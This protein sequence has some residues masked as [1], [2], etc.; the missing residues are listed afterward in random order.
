MQHP[1]KIVANFGTLLKLASDLGKANQ[2]GD[3]SKIA[4]AQAAHDNYCEIIKIAD[5]TLVGTILHE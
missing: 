3:K 1:V 4:A 2:S 5:E